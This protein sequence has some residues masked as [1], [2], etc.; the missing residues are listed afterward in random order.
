M[1][2]VMSHLYDNT[3]LESSDSISDTG[4]WN[5]HRSLAELPKKDTHEHCPVCLGIVHAKLALSNPRP[6]ECIHCRQLRGSTLERRVAFVERVLL[7]S[8]AV[9][10]TALAVFEEATGTWGDRM[11]AG[12]VMDDFNNVPLM[13]PLECREE[14]SVS[15]EAGEEFFRRSFSAG[16]GHGFPLTLRGDRWK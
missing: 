6:G 2:C 9:P 4:H 10:D 1:T 14:D 15:L 16:A 7:S 12:E 5:L 3:F 8:G 13:A 11:E